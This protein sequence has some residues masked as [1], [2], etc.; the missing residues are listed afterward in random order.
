MQLRELRLAVDRLN[1]RLDELEKSSKRQTTEL[2]KYG[3]RRLLH[4]AICELFNESELRLLIYGLGGDWEN[5]EGETVQDVALSFVLW[6]QRNGRFKELLA[7]LALD[8]P[9]V[10]WPAF[11]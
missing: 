6:M 9:G 5:L 1:G 10:D 2:A 11:G 8:R 3:K 4:S 7:A